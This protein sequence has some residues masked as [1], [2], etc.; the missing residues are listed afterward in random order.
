[1]SEMKI[2][3]AIFVWADKQTPGVELEL[4][5]PTV[6]RPKCAVALI[7]DVSPMLFDKGL[8]YL[9]GKTANDMGVLSEYLPPKEVPEWPGELLN[10]VTDDP[11]IIKIVRHLYD[12]AN[13]RNGARFE[14][15]K[16]LPKEFLS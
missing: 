2:T 7:A 9:R 3:K 11:R 16:S 15:G 14:E 13:R 1:M 4:S 10:N 12:A 8:V 5:F 6:G